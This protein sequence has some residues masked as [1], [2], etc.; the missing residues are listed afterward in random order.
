VSSTALSGAAGFLV[1]YLHRV[2][3][4]GG[5]CLGHDTQKTKPMTKT[6][7]RMTDID[8]AERFIVDVAGSA[9]LAGAPVDDGDALL[10]AA[11]L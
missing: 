1:G 8:T 5:A 11:I 2:A 4:G 6:V 9:G 7:S 3:C 10:T